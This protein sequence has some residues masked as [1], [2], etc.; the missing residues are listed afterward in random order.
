[1][2]AADVHI[3]LRGRIA[4]VTGGTGGMGRVITTEL[5]R[6]GAHVVITSRDHQ[7]GDDLRRRIAAEVGADRVE[8]LTGDL[9]SR[10]DLFRVAAGFSA[11]H[12]QFVRTSCFYLLRERPEGSAGESRTGRNDPRL[13]CRSP[14]VPHR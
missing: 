2:S 10:A 6:A 14:G 9:S 1:M 13:R 3:D 11:R 5:A 4:L 7:R 12:D 8:V